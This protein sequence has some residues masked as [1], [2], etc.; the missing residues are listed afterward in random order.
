MFLLVVVLSFVV[1]AMGSLETW[2]EQYL[3]DEHIAYLRYNATSLPGLLGLIDF[4]NPKLTMFL[5]TRPISHLGTIRNSC[6]LFFAIEFFLHFLFCPRKCAFFLNGMNVLDL[7]LLIAMVVNFVLDQYP[8]ILFSSYGA[9]MVYSI[10]HTLNFLRIWRI[11]RLMK[12]CNGLR[13]LIMSVSSSIQPLLLLLLTFLLASIL[14]GNFVFYADL[15]VPDTFPNVFVGIWWAVVTMTTVGYGDHYPKSP[16]GRV[17]GTM[18]ATCG[19]LLLSMPV[20][21]VASSFSEYF[22]LSKNQEKMLKLRKER[23]N[24]SKQPSKLSKVWAVEVAKS[25]GDR[26]DKNGNEQ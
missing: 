7:I 12:Q 15:F 8:D 14:F 10:F 23:L 4:N 16:F 5:T 2:R 1:Y 21:M 9:A 11:F 24:L 18:C 19:V 20:A 17:V 6:R 22:N 13:V 3:S 25:G 26:H